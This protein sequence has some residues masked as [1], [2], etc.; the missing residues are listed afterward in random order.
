MIPNAISRACGLI[1]KF[2]PHEGIERAARGS[3]RC[4]AVIGLAAA[5]GSFALPALGQDVETPTPG[6]CARIERDSD[7]LACYDQLN[8]GDDD[9]VEADSAR[10][11]QADR[12]EAPAQTPAEAP[13]QRV[14]EPVAE[15]PV[16]RAAETAAE[17]PAETQRRA[18]RSERRRPAP[19][20]ERESEVREPATRAAQE[21]GEPVVI[22]EVRR[23]FVGGWWFFTENGEV[24]RQTSRARG[25]FPEAP[26][27]ARLEEASRNTYF[28]SSPLGGPIVRVIRDD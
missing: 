8:A 11:R 2:R 21:P 10:D 19:E 7:R 9:E 6:D 15:A 5:L 17:A 16:Q 14:A 25:R 24:L 4:P 27:T 23:S 1:Q 3:R 22:V 26:F 13:A 12:R 18:E 20:Q 28:L